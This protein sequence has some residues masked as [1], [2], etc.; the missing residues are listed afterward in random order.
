MR[1]PDDRRRWGVV[2]TSEFRK[3]WE[4][5]ADELSRPAEH[6]YAIE[7]AISRNPRKCS[8]AFVDEEQR[9]LVMN[10]PMDR[11]GIWV[12]FRM[13]PDKRECELGWAHVKDL[14]NGDDEE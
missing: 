10:D 2:K 11:K 5:A 4:N 12:F 7:R 14:E 9:V 3:C 6:L 13:V 8:T 1:M